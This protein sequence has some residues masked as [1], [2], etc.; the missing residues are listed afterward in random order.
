MERTV[1]IKKIRKEDAGVLYDMIREMAG[2]E[3]ELD[4]VK[5]SKQKIEQTICNGMDANCFITWVD[6]EPAAYVVYFYTYSTYLGCRNLY[7]EDVFVRPA[8]R[9][10]GLGAKI[11]RFMARLAIQEGCPRMDWT[12]LDWNTNAISF[13]KHLG[14]SHLKERYYFRADGKALEELACTEE[15]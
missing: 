11:L 15:A 14:A 5:T 1:E 10:L 12:C 4:E 6:G 3:H 2:Y 8:Y 9:N 7:V 13:Y